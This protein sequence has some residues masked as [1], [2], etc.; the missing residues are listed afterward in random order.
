MLLGAAI[1]AI[2]QR[3]PFI[4][5]YDIHG[6]I[7]ARG[8]LLSMADTALLVEG[9]PENIFINRPEISMVITKH[10]AG[11]NVLGGMR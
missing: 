5:V 6:H 2:S 8:W 11:S 7:F 10:G 3:T 9:R 4:R 1:Q